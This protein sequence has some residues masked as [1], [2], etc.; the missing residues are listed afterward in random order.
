MHPT[1]EHLDRFVDGELSELETEVVSM[2]LPGCAQCGA[3]ARQLENLKLR[4]ALEPR[5]IAPPL[6]VWEGIRQSLP[7]RRMNPQ[8]FLPSRSRRRVM[9]WGSAALIL[10]A[11]V[12][13]WVVPTVGS[14]G[15][16]PERRA[17]NSGGKAV[18]SGDASE[19]TRELRG[20]HRERGEPMS[21]TPSSDKAAALTRLLDEQRRFVTAE[22]RA[23]IEQNIAAIESATEATRRALVADPNNVQLE[24]MLV[25]ARR[26]REEYIRSTTSIASDL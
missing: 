7:S 6:D 4:V 23:S 8:P 26:L 17:P 15:R 13:V 2:H 22:T 11:S 12:A 18:V 3:A 14:S 24:V 10:A 20:A 5:E 9:A 19:E 16:V 21:A 1:N 25:R